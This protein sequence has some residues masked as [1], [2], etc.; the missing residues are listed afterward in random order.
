MAFKLAA[1]FCDGF[2]PTTYEFSSKS[3]GYSIQDLV[4]AIKDKTDYKFV[5]SYRGS[6][7]E[8]KVARS[9]QSDPAARR[10]T[11]PL[12]TNGCAP[13]RLS[14]FEAGMQLIDTLRPKDQQ[15]QQAMSVTMTLGN[16]E[17]T[18]NMKPV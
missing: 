7:S 13:N 3:G 18:I 16:T 5:K 6:P 1:T 4:D 8:I 14:V 17:L 2:V 9:M 12:E 10:K 11:P 15:A